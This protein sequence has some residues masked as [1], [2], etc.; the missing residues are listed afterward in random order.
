MI[1]NVIGAPSR[2]DENTN[3]SCRRRLLKPAFLT[4]FRSAVTPFGNDAWN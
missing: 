2:I 1:E 4:G 3:I